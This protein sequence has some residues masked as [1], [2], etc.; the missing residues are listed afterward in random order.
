MKFL[1]AHEKFKKLSLDKKQVWVV[2][3][4]NSTLEDLYQDIEISFSEGASAV[5]LEGKDY[6]KL[7]RALK[8][9]KE[10]F[11][12]HVFG[13]N[14]LGPDNHLHSYKE[15]FFLA[16][17][18]HL[19][20]A[21]TDFSGVDLIHEAPEVSLHD[22]EKNKPQDIFYVSGIHMKYSTL[23]DSNKSIEKSALQAMGWVD[24]IVITGA[25][26]AESI[27][28]EKVRRVRKVIGNYPLGV[29]SGVSA[30][31]CHEIREDIDFVIVNSSIS[32]SNHRIL[33][34]KVAELCK[35]LLSC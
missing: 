15:T 30:A 10:S 6:L 19:Q 31:N 17:K 8:V 34:G 25:K 16:Q 32:D 7:D 13:V 12:A 1:S 33:K 28:P 11:S 9:A 18:Y 26:T 20:I 24:G 14:F 29:G 27:D 22:I 23:I 5:L 4:V 21:W 3:Y 35:N 2:V